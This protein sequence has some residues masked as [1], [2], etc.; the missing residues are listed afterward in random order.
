[1]NTAILPWYVLHQTITILL[2]WY[3][4]SL[5]MN[6]GLEAA[7]VVVGTVAGCAIGYEIIRR[8]TVIRFMFGLKYE[9][10]GPAKTDDP[11]YSTS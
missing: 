11:V 3:L 6:T 1:M 8:F 5:G 4:S 2:A 10:P 9:K 7:L